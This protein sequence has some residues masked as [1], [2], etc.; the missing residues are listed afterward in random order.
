MTNVTFQLSQQDEAFFMSVGASYAESELTA[1]DALESFAKKVTDKP[2]Y[3]VWVAGS[4]A[5]KKAYAKTKTDA[6]GKTF[7]TDSEAVRKA[8]SRFTGKLSDKYA[9]SKPAKPTETGKAKANQRSKAKAELEELV[10][11]DTEELQEQIAMLT[12][13]PSK[14]N[15]AKAS[16]L[17][18]AVEAKAKAETKEATEAIKAL[19]KEAI[20]AIKECDSEIVLQDVIGLLSNY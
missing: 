10:K 15:L 4:E 9:I 20:E 11:L 8:W 5:W 12:A 19:R 6:E 16:K 17:V 13:T 2:D 7:T 3:Y 1:D 18:K 14:E